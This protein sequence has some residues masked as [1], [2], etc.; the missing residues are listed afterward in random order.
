MRLEGPLVW[1]AVALCA[2]DP[3]GGRELPARP[4]V[5]CPLALVR[6]LLAPCELHD[7]LPEKI[8]SHSDA[9]LL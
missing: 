5:L 3:G 6:G 9:I 4:Q 8:H 1:H 7:S 2:R